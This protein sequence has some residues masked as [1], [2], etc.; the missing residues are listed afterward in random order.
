MDNKAL[1]GINV[2]EMGTFIAVPTCARF[3]ADMGA[4]VIKIE[5]PSGDPTRWNSVSEGRPDD[6]IFENTS[7]EGENS[8][9]RG[10]ILNTK[11]EQGK[12]ILFRLLS[13]ADV[14]LTNWRPQALQ[15]NGLDYETLK[16]KFP[17][18]VYGSLTGYG[19]KGPDKDLPGF[20]FTSFFARGGLAGSLYQ[21]G[22]RPMNL[23]PGIGDHQA[24][25]FLAAGVLAALYKAK[26]TGKGD[27]VTTNL[28]HASIFVQSTMVQGA[29][30]EDLGQ[31]YPVDAA[32][33]DNPFN[34]AYKT[35]DERWLQLAAVVFDKYYPQLMPLLGRE[36]LVGDPRYT[37]ANI[38]KERLNREFCGI[39]AEAFEK[40][41]LAEW[42]EILTAHDIPFS[43]MQ[44][45]EEVL[46]D[47]Q[48]W[49]NDV[50]YRMPYP[51]GERTL[52]R[53]P[54]FLKE[55][56]VPQFGMGPLLGEHSEEILRELGYT[57]AELSAMKLAG[58]YVDWKDIKEKYHG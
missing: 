43:P 57:E 12:Q 19:E 18:L 26:Q 15:K 14:F 53:L 58:A 39:L 54:V 24:G 27:K 10:L 44:T 2:V 5:A 9:K 50:F 47:P 3:L 30:Y 46:V 17:H 48:A 1:S 45:W 42:S 51:K 28:L 49:A 25:M 36:D 35:K 22:T 52:V 29:Q 23:V 34:C 20:D 56:G 21:K 4:N 13:Q 7:W 16:E 38:S 31:K 40:K 32:E 55:D 41:T 33:A 6:F 11:T 8:N 37:I